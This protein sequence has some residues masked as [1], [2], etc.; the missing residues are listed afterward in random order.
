MRQATLHD[1]G[2]TPPPVLQTTP[3]NYLHTND[4]P[5]TEPTYIVPEPIPDPPKEHVEPHECPGE[6]VELHAF[7]DDACPICHRPQSIVP[8]HILLD[9]ADV[10][11]DYLAANAP[12]GNGFE[13]AEDTDPIEPLSSGPAMFAE[14]PEPGPGQRLH[15]KDP[16]K[17]NDCGERMSSGYARIFSTETGDL[18]CPD[19]RSRAERYSN[20]GY[21][22]GGT[23]PDSVTGSDNP[24]YADLAGEDT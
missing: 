4:T 23:T 12:D 14:A 3:A 2:L 21:E 13:T 17:C 24:R 19:C 6:Q 18:Y 16:R 20:Q 9:H 1:F 8:E 11:N 10:V 7:A 15:P 5:P 22:T